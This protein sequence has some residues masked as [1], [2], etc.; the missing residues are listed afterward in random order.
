[1]KGVRIRDAL[2]FLRFPNALVRVLCS[3]PPPTLCKCC[4]SKV[5]VVMASWRVPQRS[6]MSL[7][8]GPKVRWCWR[9]E[10]WWSVTR[11]IPDFLSEALETVGALSEPR[12]SL[13][14]SRR[15]ILQGIWPSADPVCCPPSHI[16]KALAFRLPHQNLSTLPLRPSASPS[17]SSSPLSTFYSLQ[18][19]AQ[20]TDLTWSR[21]SK[22]GTVRTQG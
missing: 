2:G 7:D 12:F 16:L 13:P 9:E 18:H 19:S 1:M 10:P 6:F 11:E 21:P 14:P 8:Y 22:Q 17:L 3:P 15:Q 4:H 20:V 5:A